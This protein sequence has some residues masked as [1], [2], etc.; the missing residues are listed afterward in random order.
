[1]TISL[2]ICLCTL[3]LT[4]MVPKTPP[5]PPLLRIT[6]PLCLHLL[7]TS[8]FVLV[9]DWSHRQV[10]GTLHHFLDLLTHIRTSHLQTPSAPLHRNSSIGSKLDLSHYLVRLVTVLFSLLPIHPSWTSAHPPP[11]TSGPPVPTSG[12]YLW[13]SI[14]P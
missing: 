12:P 14:P 6:Y 5:P 11:P 1:M 3:R 9:S 13:T 2:K 4:P 10:V 7:W 8:A